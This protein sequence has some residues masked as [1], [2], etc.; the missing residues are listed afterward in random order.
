MNISKRKTNSFLSLPRSCPSKSSSHCFSFFD[1]RND[2][3]YQKGRLL[4]LPVEHWNHQIKLKKIHSQKFAKTA[5]SCCVRLNKFIHFCQQPNS[6]RIAHTHTFRWTCV[7]WQPPTDTNL[8]SHGD[9]HV[10]SHIFARINEVANCWDSSTQWTHP[11]STPTIHSIIILLLHYARN[12]TKMSFIKFSIR[13]GY[14]SLTLSVSCELSTAS[15]LSSDTDSHTQKDEI[16]Q[17]LLNVFIINNLTSIFL[18]WQI[19]SSGL[20]TDGFIS[21]TQALNWSVCY[22]I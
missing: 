5:T 8:L 2:E 12:A 10:H 7:E 15:Q 20:V 11:P 6:A 17:K 4:K 1:D 3:N 16:I 14:V 9:V 22:G 13:S 19:E 18:A 21:P